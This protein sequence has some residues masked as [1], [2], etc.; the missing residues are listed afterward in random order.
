MGPVGCETNLTQ[1]LVLIQDQLIQ[2][3]MISNLKDIFQVHKL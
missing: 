3:D 1:I 2:W